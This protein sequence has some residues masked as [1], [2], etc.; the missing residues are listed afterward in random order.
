MEMH[1]PFTSFHKESPVPGYS[2]L[3]LSRYLEFF[4]MSIKGWNWGQMENVRHSIDLS[5]EV[6]ER[7]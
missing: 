4:V 1:V 3:N 2:G 7:F 5:M 6:S